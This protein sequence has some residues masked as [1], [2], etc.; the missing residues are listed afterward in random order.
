MRC[1]KFFFPFS[2]LVTIEGKGRKILKGEKLFPFLILK[3]AQ[4]CTTI[5]ILSNALRISNYQQMIVPVYVN[6]E[7]NL[8]TII[9]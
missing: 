7:I 8:N 4:K 5:P 1:G 6:A 3:F 9:C 2:R